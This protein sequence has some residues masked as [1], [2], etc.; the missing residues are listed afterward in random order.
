MLEEIEK[1]K[2][3][4]KVLLK[5]Y[6]HMSSTNKS[7]ERTYYKL[8]GME[9]ILEILDVDINQLQKEVYDAE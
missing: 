4:Y 2:N 8:F 9:R 5:E 6:K 3:K 1:A 7:Y